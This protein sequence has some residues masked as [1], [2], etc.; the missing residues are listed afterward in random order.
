MSTH[1]QRARRNTRVAQVATLALAVGAAALAFTSG[2][3]RSDDGPALPPTIT[4]KTGETDAAANSLSLDRSLNV[5][6]NLVLSQAI[7]KPKVQVPDEP[8]NIPPTPPPPPPPSDTSWHYVGSIIGSSTSHAFIVSASGQQHL[9][10]Q[11]QDLEGITLVSVAPDKLVIRDT[12]GEHSI[13]LDPRPANQVPDVAARSGG[14][15]GAFGETPPDFDKLP[16]EEQN[17]W[18]EDIARRKMEAE[19]RGVKPATPPVRPAPRPNMPNV[20]KQPDRK[21]GEKLSR[22]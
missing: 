20:P 14:T 6:Q 21:P 17:R 13:A 15:A 19:K 1:R 18:R 5:L 11:G 4:G 10:A 9:L 2:S 16:L 7:E 8:V 22:S 3:V 12:T